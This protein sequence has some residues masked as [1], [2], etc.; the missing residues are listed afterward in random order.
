MPMSRRNKMGFPSK[1]GHYRDGLYRRKVSAPMNVATSGPTYINQDQSG[2]LFYV[3]LATTHTFVLPKISSKWLGLEYTFFVS[4][5]ASSLDVKINCVLDSSAKIQMNFSSVI[6]NH[7]TIIPGSTMASAVR[8]TAVSSVVWMG[9]PIMSNS[10][11]FTSAA[12]ENL[13]GWTT[14]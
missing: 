1:I 13:C 7:S 5:Q 9:Q 10:Y 8:L 3:P 2:M 12:T 4:E 14:G 11:T 6:D